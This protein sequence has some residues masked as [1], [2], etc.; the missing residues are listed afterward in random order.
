MSLDSGLVE[1]GCLQGLQD[2]QGL[3]ER[4]FTR[5]LCKCKVG[6]A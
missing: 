1:F 5:A 4:I 6:A 3:Q 2:L